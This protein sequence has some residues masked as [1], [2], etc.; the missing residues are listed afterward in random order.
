MTDEILEKD[1]KVGGLRL[2]NV[3]TDEVCEIEV[4]GV[5]VAVGNVPATDFVR[6]ILP[7]RALPPR[8]PQPPSRF[9]AASFYDSRPQQTHPERSSSCSRPP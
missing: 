2:R 9:A 3:K 7:R 5:F 8:R 4:N 6:D 1:G